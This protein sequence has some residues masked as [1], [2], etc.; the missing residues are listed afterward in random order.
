VG[1]RGSA[2]TQSYPA[3]RELGAQ[4]KPPEIAGCE[5]L[6]RPAVYTLVEKNAIEIAK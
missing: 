6:V 3:C 5:C 2:V 1:V 4:I